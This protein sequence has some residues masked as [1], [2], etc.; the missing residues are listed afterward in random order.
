[1]VDPVGELPYLPNLG[2]D[3]LELLPLGSAPETLWQVLTFPK[4]SSY[5]QFCEI[6]L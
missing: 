1:M 6:Y 4:A 2:P 5:L 3:I